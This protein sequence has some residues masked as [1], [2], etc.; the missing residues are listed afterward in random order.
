MLSR[1]EI[2]KKKKYI[3]E[4]LKTQVSGIEEEKLKSTLLS[5]MALETSN[6]KLKNV[7]MH[8]LLGKISNGVTLEKSTQKVKVIWNDLEKSYYSHIDND[9]VM[10]LLQ[11]ADNLSQIQVQYDED[12]TELQPLQL[13]NEYVVKLSRIFYE[14]LGDKDISE[15]AR[16]I[17]DDETHFGFTK[18][19]PIG[20]EMDYGMTFYDTVFATIS[21]AALSSSSTASNTSPFSFTRKP[22]VRSSAKE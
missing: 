7:K 9:Y 22:V 21:N 19:V 18:A 14:G 1:S 8:N 20:H 4:K 12:A 3:I 2:Q 11:M 16:T 17:L 13:S 6:D 15:K 10:F 5:L